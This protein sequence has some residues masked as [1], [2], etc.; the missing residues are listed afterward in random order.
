MVKKKVFASTIKENGD[1]GVSLMHFVGKN[2][3]EALT[4]LE[5]RR[6]VMETGAQP[7]TGAC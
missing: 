7:A 5:C 4:P 2:S 1:I 6:S 3:G